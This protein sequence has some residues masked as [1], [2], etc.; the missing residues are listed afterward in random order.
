MNCL[1]AIN[2]PFPGLFLICVNLIRGGEL[3]PGL[4]IGPRQNR[5]LT[6]HHPIGRGPGGREFADYWESIQKA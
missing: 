6:F 5:W 1:R 2:S 3:T 4:G